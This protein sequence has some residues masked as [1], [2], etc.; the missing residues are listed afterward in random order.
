MRHIFNRTSNKPKDIVT[1]IP[2]KAKESNQTPVKPICDTILATVTTQS[3]SDA[4]TA[5]IITNILNFFHEPNGP[6]F[7]GTERSYLNDS[8]D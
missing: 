4:P 5:R 2:F 1:C 7:I 6:L 8:D 3:K